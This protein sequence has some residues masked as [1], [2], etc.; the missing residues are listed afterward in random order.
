VFFFRHS[1]CSLGRGWFDVGPSRGPKWDRG[2]S[3][4]GHG[5]TGSA[6]DRPRCRYDDPMAFSTCAAQSGSQSTVPGHTTSGRY[7]CARSQSRF[8]LHYTD[9]TYQSS[10]SSLAG[11]TI[12]RLN[13]SERI[14]ESN[15]A[16]ILLNVVESLRMFL[17]LTYTLYSIVAVLFWFSNE[18][19]FV[20]IQLES[21]NYDN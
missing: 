15:I 9:Y 21:Y 20:K 5:G 8:A 19:S 17:V 6:D 1:D 10:L 18:L 16:N 4:G 12:Q 7:A 14:R 13:C 11:V 3:R 2:S